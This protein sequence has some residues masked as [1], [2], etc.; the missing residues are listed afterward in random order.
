[1]MSLSQ[2]WIGKLERNFPQIAKSPRLNLLRVCDGLA[3]VRITLII[4]N[5]K[6]FLETCLSDQ[7]NRQSH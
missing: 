2:P 7:Q 3:S 4:A 6:S 5:L 1:M